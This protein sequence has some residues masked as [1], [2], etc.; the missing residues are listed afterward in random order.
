MYEPLV[1]LWQRVQSHSCVCLLLFTEA[2][3][4]V[5]ATQIKSAF[6]IKDCNAVTHCK[7]ISIHR[8]N[9]FTLAMP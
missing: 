2:V 1:S 3:K 8:G 4:F 6:H 5:A 9:A 7:P